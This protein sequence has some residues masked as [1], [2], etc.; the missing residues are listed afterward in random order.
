MPGVRVH[1]AEGGRSAEA[2]GPAGE[3]QSA[4]CQVSAEKR[5]QKQNNGK[6][7]DRNLG[8][9]DEHSVCREAHDGAFDLAE[10]EV[11]GHGQARKDDDDQH[12]RVGAQLF[13]EWQQAEPVGS[14]GQTEEAGN[15]RRWNEE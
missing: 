10:V 7:A 2:A 1:I 9:V 13:G 12:G 4:D 3:Q 6:N 11:I 5:T 8:G 14:Q 15:E